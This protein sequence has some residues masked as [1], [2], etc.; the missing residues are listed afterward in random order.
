MALRSWMRRLRR[1]WNSRLG[2]RRSTAPLRRR[3]TSIYSGVLVA[4][5]LVH[6]R[7]P[8]R[9]K[10]RRGH[11]GIGLDTQGLSELAPIHGEDDA[12]RAGIDRLAR[13]EP[14]LSTRWRGAHRA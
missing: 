14:K 13:R 10:Q 5:F 1:L 9:G 3:Y 6:V 4:I 11:G 12:V 7:R 2:L 8:F